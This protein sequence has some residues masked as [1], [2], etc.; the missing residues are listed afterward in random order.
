MSDQ[1]QKSTFVTVL[2]WIFIVFA[3]FSSFIGILQN[4]MLYMVFPREAMSQH[5]SNSQFPEEIPAIFKF[6]MLNVEWFF[7]LVLV[8]SIVTFISA[9]ALLKRKNWAR[10]VFIILMFLGIAWNVGGLVFQFLFMKNMTD[11]AGTPPP[12]EFQTMETVMIVASTIMVIAFVA[13]FGWV[14]KKLLS[15][16]IKAEF[17]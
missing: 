12:P 10:I 9:I 8:L 14:I 11:I 13:L 17:A 7:L 2:A 4:I 3:G 15:D 5:A 1:Q 6:M 16:P